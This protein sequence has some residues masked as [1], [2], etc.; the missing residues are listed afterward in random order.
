[1]ELDVGVIA[2]YKR[3]ICLY[4]YTI[5][6]V[7]VI[8]SLVTVQAALEGVRGLHYNR[9]IRIKLTCLNAV[10]LLSICYHIILSFPSLYTFCKYYI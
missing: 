8:L 5:E 4:Y 7:I 1:M 6:S 10:L 2:L 9:Q 3:G